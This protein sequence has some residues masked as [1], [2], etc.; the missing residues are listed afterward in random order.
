MKTKMVCLVKYVRLVFLA[1]PYENEYRSLF[2]TP[3]CDV[4]QTIDSTRDCSF[5]DPI[6]DISDYPDPVSDVSNDTLI[7]P[8]WDLP[9]SPQYSSDISDLE[10][11][12]T[13]NEVAIPNISIPSTNPVAV[14]SSL[15]SS[16]ITDSSDASDSSEP[17]NLN[18]VLSWTMDFS[19][20]SNL[21]SVSSMTCK[22]RFV[23]IY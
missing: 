19:L 7:L 5:S 2:D 9:D 14:A 4:D 18:R 11:I 23:F 3:L 22:Q 10:T 13:S 15:V 16:E 8:S 6:V 12:E 17:V 21:C 1:E 20:L